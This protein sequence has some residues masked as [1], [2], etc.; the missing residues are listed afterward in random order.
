MAALGSGSRESAY[1]QVTSQGCIHLFPDAC[2]FPQA[3]IVFGFLH[4]FLERFKRS[5]D[6]Q[7]ERM[8]EHL[9]QTRQ[10]LDAAE[11]SVRLQ[12]RM[13]QNI[14]DD[15]RI[16]ADQLDL[17][18]SP[19]DLLVLVKQAMAKQQTS[20]P[21][22]AIELKIL[23]PEPTIPVLADAGRITQVLTLYLANALDSSSAERPVT[24]Q[25]QEEDQMAR[26]SVHDEGPGIPPEEEGRLWDR[27]YRGKGSSVQH[28]L[29]LSLGC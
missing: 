15:A 16:Q 11:Q 4:T 20:V 2:L 14:I 21:E 24:V 13:I 18:L 28:E 3:E 25:V 17:S 12:E 10:S 22:R 6:Q 9:E 8:S 27:F 19:C 29:D 7:S 26:V 5:L 1:A 23:T